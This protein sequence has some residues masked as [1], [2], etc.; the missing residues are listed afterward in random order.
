MNNSAQSMSYYSKTNH[1]IAELPHQDKLRSVGKPVWVCVVAI[2][3]EWIID[4]QCRNINALKQSLF[5]CFV[6]FEQF[7]DNLHCLDISKTTCTVTNNDYIECVLIIVENDLL[8]GPFFNATFI[9]IPKSHL[10][11]CTKSADTWR[12]SD[13]RLTCKKWKKND[14]MSF[15]N[16]NYI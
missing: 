8:V 1:S 13:L 2:A 7:S 6:N 12:K 4:M 16:A 3:H 5:S 11:F 9:S 14:V 10:N 15:W